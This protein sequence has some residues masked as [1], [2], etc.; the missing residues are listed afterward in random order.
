[1]DTDEYV[2]EWEQSLI[3]K[4]G[5]LRDGTGPLFNVAFCDPSFRS[6]LVTAFGVTYDNLLALSKDDRCVVDFETLQL[7]SWTGCEIE[8]A[9]TSPVPPLNAFGQRFATH[10]DLHNDS[11]CVVP[12][13]ALV[14]RICK[15]ESPESAAT[16]PLE[17]VG[18]W[19]ERF[20]SLQA[21]SE[22]PRSTGDY[23]HLFAEVKRGC[24][25]Q[26]SA[27]GRGVIRFRGKIYP[28][29][30]A[31]LESSNWMVDVETFWYRLEREYW[32]VERA[33]TQRMRKDEPTRQ[34]YRDIQTSIVVF[35]GCAKGLTAATSAR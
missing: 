14:R 31:V 4:M 2:C 7:R 15:G 20:P 25:H 27:L 12:L 28:N 30:E 1:M 16:R 10:Q 22:D 3:R 26:C 23:Q 34:R 5:T 17:W 9:A 33:A 6:D 18:A 35:D 32:T 19:G 13:T 11:R 21:L 24:E 29:A 8:L